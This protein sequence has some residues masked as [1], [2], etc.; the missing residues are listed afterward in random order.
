MMKL[1]ATILK[2]LAPR[3]TSLAFKPES[4]SCF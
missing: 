4:L 3:T 2:S 1:R